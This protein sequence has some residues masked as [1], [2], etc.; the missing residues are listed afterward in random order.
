MN[1]YI[2]ISILLYIVFYYI[3]FIQIDD[4]PYDRYGGYDEN[5][6]RY[7]PIN[8]PRHL[9]YHPFGMYGRYARRYKPLPVLFEKQ[10]SPMYVTFLYRHIITSI[11]V[12]Y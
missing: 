12:C 9:E 3:Y 5:R 8:T 7:E 1:I 11:H 4:L 2:N 10:T 6:R